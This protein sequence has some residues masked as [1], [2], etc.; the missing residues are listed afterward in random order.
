MANDMKQTALQRFF[1]RHPE[2]VQSAV[3][4]EVGISQSHLSLLVSGDRDPSVDVVRRL[5]GV[6]QKYEPTL[7]FEH[8]FSSEAA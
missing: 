4:T 7:T 1:Q 5:L 3:A 2:L 8:L 6:L